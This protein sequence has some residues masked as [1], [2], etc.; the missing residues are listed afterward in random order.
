[1]NQDRRNGSQNGYSSQNQGYS[2]P[3]GGYPGATGAYG[4]SYIPQTPSYYQQ[5]GGQEGPAQGYGAQGAGTQGYAAAGYPP[6][7]GSPS[8]YPGGAGYATAGQGYPVPGQG[9]QGYPA[10]G[11]GMTGYTAGAQGYPGGA[12]YATAGQG[13]PVPGQ[14]G[15]GY[16]APGQGVTGYAAGGQGYPAPGQGVTGYAAVGQG[17]PA[18]GYATG[19]PQAAG[20]P[21]M[22]YPQAGNASGRGQ[23]PINGGGYVPQQVPVRK[24]PFVV[25]DTM[26]II[27]GAVLILLLAAGL[28]LKIDVLKWIFLVLGAGLIAFLWVRPVTA[29]NRRLCFTIVFAAL[30]VVAV[31]SLLGLGGSGGVDR[32]N[33]PGGGAAAAGAAG[34][35]GAS[36][37]GAG[38][39]VVT[40]RPAAAVTSTPEPDLGEAVTERLYQFFHYWSAN[41]T[42]EMLTLCSPSWQS[43]T[44]NPKADL[45]GLL[46][47]RTPL[48][49]T[50]ESISG[51]NDDQSRTVTLNTLMD[52]NNGKDPS[53]YRLNVIMVRDNDLWYVDPQSLQ[54]YEAAD[55]PDPNVTATPAPTPELQADASTVLYYNPDGGTKYHLDPNCKS[56]HQKYLPFKGHFTYGEINQSEYVK[57]SP[58]NVCGAPLRP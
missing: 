45:F 21:Q 1:M 20:Q 38:A 40:E 27:A 12:G 22:P 17:Y 57:L 58:C 29:K 5:P 54:T 39:T 33:L 46:A 25:N 30:A 19:Y 49:Y 14:G 13:Y 26:L 55:T 7:G 52:R 2:Y 31:I 24:R 56:T 43:K 34:S 36:G 32:Q 28:V 41:Q 9:G 6:A 48:D 53:R 15:Q 3:Q 44:D 10:P 4:T 51:T 23:M 8:G 42:D 50:F 47:N 18:Q 37:G 11:Q 16:P 35:A